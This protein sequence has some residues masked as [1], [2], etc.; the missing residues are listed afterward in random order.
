MTPYDTAAYGRTK[1]LYAISISSKQWIS[2][3]NF[4]RFILF[5]G[6]T[7]P[8]QNPF[9]RTPQ[10]ISFCNSTVSTLK[11]F[12]K[13]FLNRWILFSIVL[14][15]EVVFVFAFLT[16]RG[17]KKDLKNIW[18]MSLLTLNFTHT[19]GNIGGKSDTEFTGNRLKI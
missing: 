1:W 14:P 18:S 6:C 16:W 5:F 2:C 4:V 19:S 12:R 8:C 17:K 3:E 15:M 13:L 10:Y 9:T 11:S 7:T